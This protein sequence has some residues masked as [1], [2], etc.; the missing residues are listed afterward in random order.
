MKSFEL[1]IIFGLILFIAS[2][3]TTKE[4]PPRKT[5][6][7]K[8]ELLIQNPPEKNKVWVFLMAGQSNMAGRGGVQPQDT[9]PNARILSINKNNEF[10][11]AKEPLHFYEPSM[12]GLDCGMS[13]ASELLPHVPDSVTLLLLPTAV[14]GSSIEQ[15]IGDSTHRGV[16]LLSNFKSKMELGKQIGI[17]KGILWHQGES[18]SGS[19]QQVEAQPEKMK[20]LFT[21]FREYAENLELPILIGE[22]GVFG[23]QPNKKLMNQKFDEFAKTN[24]S[25]SVITTK[26][27]Q[28]KGDHTHFNCT[29]Q[30][31]MGKRFA[32]E[33]V[34]NYLKI[35]YD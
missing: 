34:S 7:P 8:E 26:D 9:V 10:V 27:L 18:N 15:W 24:K 19:I 20:R 21:E 22:L 28:H 25:F 6:F 11:V 14:G 17:I 16:S 3:A 35:E 1:K 29:S 23:K 32:R 33:F 4:V 31:E 5:F 30:R 13:F 12:T 2:C